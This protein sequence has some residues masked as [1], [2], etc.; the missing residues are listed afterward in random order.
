MIELRL[1]RMLDIVRVLGLFPRIPQNNGPG[2]PILDI[3]IQLETL[4]RVRVSI[5]TL[6]FAKHQKIVIR[7]GAAASSSATVTNCSYSWKQHI[8]GQPNT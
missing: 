5:P 3:L 6:I 8:V 1:R 2:S 7:L 4:V